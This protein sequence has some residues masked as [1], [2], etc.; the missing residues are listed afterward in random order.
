VVVEEQIH[1]VEFSITHLSCVDLVLEEEHDKE[2]RKDSVSTHRTIPS[3]LP[4][5]LHNNIWIA[6]KSS[7][8]QDILHLKKES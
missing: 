3:F 2:K 7:I 1:A 5:A 6:L 4:L 8:K